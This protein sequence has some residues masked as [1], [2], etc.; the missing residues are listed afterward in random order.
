MDLNP[1]R[2]YTVGE[3]FQGWDAFDVVVPKVVASSNLGLK[4]A[5]AFGVNPSAKLA[6]LGR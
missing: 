2:G 3:P 4:L 6:D 5:N 1:E